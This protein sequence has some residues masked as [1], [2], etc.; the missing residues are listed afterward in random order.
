MKY[1]IV[2]SIV[3][4]L[5][6]PKFKADGSDAHRKAWQLEH[7]SISQPTLI[8]PYLAHI[9]GESMRGLPAHFEQ[10]NAKE[11]FTQT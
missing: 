5:H 2:C 11:N 7:L 8:Q 4:C 6:F 9:S 1:N 10:C 3:S